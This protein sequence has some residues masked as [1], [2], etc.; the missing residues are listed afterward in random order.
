MAKPTSVAGN[1]CGDTAL[2]GRSRIPCDASSLV[3]HREGARWVVSSEDYVPGPGPGDFVHRWDTAEQA[4][5]DIVDFYFGDPRR[6]AL[7]RR[8]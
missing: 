3:L 1:S 2:W 6:M 4:V 5:A 7:K 8:R